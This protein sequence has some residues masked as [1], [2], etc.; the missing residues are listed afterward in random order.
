MIMYTLF[1]WQFEDWI[2]IAE[3]DLITIVRGNCSTH[4]FGWG[5]IDDN[6]TANLVATWA[7]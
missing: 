7:V 2:E 4:T 5:S 6:S 3:Y 1:F